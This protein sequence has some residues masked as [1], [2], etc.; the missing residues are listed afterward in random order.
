MRKLMYGII[1]ATLFIIF[2]PAPKASAQ[3]QIGIG[4]GVEPSCPYGYYGYAPY[5]C[6]PYGY[7]SDD[8]FNGGAFIGAGRWYRGNRGY[9]GHVNRSFDPR[10]GYRGAYPEHGGYHQPEDNFRSFQATHRANPNGG[11]RGD[12]HMHGTGGDRG[13]HGGGGDHGGGHH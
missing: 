3:I 13:A 2:T 7:Y 10:Y 12:D 6:A 1:A 11:Y 9:Y 5:Q 4:V 8:W